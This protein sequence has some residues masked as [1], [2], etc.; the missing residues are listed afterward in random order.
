[1]NIVERILEEN[2]GREGRVA[3]V[4]DSRSMTYAELF[5]AVASWRRRLEELGITQPFKQAHREVYLLTEAERRDADVL[6]GIAHD[7]GTDTFLVTGKHWPALF[8][9]R[10][11]PAS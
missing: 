11:V 10:F 2:R 6:N 4:E 7:D 9:V 5:A 3:L 8:R 1:M